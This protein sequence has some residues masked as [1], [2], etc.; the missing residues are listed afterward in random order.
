MKLGLVLD[1]F[2]GMTM[3]TL[4][5]RRGNRPVA[6]C[7]LTVTI[8]TMYLVLARQEFPVVERLPHEAHRLFRLNMAGQT[9]SSR[10]RLLLSTVEVA[11][12]ACGF[13]NADVLTLDGLP[14]TTN[15]V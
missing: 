1:L 4:A 9:L 12:Q 13:T 10:H 6:L 8:G 15:T 5:A 11:S 3:A 2:E 7:H 14:V